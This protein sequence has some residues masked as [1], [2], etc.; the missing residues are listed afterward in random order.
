MSLLAATYPSKGSQSQLWRQVRLEILLNY[1]FAGSI[2]YKYGIISGTIVSNWKSC[3]LADS[4]RLHSLSQ[5]I[6]GDKG[7]ELSSWTCPLRKPVVYLWKKHVYAAG[8]ITRQHLPPPMNDYLATT[9]RKLDKCYL[10]KGQYW[11][12]KHNPDIPVSLNYI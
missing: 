1:R 5:M 4:K 12:Q 3:C 10:V 11:W 7:Q 2:F 8:L 9:H 6:T